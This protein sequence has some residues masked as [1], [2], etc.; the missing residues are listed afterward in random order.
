[1]VTA[2]CTNLVW[3]QIFTTLFRGNPSNEVM[4]QMVRWHL[5]ILCG[6]ALF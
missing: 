4:V 2:G 5:S 3:L 1:M 6:S